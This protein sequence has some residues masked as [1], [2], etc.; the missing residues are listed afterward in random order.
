M[1]NTIPAWI[2]LLIVVA[3]IFTGCIGRETAEPT[4]S[5]IFVTEEA[6]EAATETTE[7]VTEEPAADYN[8]APQEADGYVHSYPLGTTV[9]YDLNGDG[10]GEDITVLATGENGNEAELTINGITVDAGAWGVSEY[11]TVIHPDASKDILLVGVSSYGSD[12]FWTALYAYDGT[13]ISKVDGFGDIVGEGNWRAGTVFHGD[14]TLTARRHF[15]V[16]GT[17]RGWGRYEVDENSVRDITEFYSFDPWEENQPGW[18]VTTKVDV[19][20]YE[21]INDP[22][23]QTVIPAG[24]AAY[25]TGCKK[26][27]MDE[28]WAAFEI[29]SMGKTLW[30]HTTAADWQTAVQTPDGY[31]NS[32][33]AFDGFWYAG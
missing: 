24:T 14:G 1:K 20:M 16:L 18:E 19:L 13:E 31:L 5:V 22:N 25:M 33:E 2:C 3:L 9:R 15:D 27:S 21:D 8:S 7:A 30:L 11:Y 23:S 12:D 17:W 26:L 4:D 10:V 28:H 32:E 6:T 29:E